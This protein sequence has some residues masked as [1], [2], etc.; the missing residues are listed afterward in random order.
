VISLL[1]FSLLSLL[2]FVYFPLGTSYF[3]GAKVL[4]GEIIIFLILIIRLFFGPKL[5]MWNSNKVVLT[6]IGMLIIISGV[7]LFTSQTETVIFG[8]QFRLQGTLLLWSLLI[9]SVLTNDISIEKYIKRWFILVV[10]ALQFIFTVLF[11]GVGAQRPIGTLGEPNALAANAVFLW[12]FLFI[13][14]R[15]NS[16]QPGSGRAGKVKAWN[17]KYWII[18]SAGMIMTCIIILVSGSRSGVIALG[19][20]VIFLYFVRAFYGRTLVATV[21]ALVVLLFSFATVPYVS[22]GDKYENRAEIWQSALTAAF[23]T[24]LTGVGF[25]NAEYAL[26]DATV[27]LNN[28]LQGYYVDSSHNIFLDYLVQGGIGA[29][30][31]L[32]LLIFMTIRSFV[33]AENVRNLVLFLGLIASLSF[34]PGSV[35]SLLVFWWLIGQGITK[36]YIN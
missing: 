34:N 26:H 1:I 36:R 7:H 31:A 11:I 3:E 19:V 2:Q 22:K 21:I 10:I 8:N 6:G 13:P 12:P 17:I 30:L 23:E 24:P 18:A 16:L 29:L 5:Q 33:R 20:Q 32:S 28:H 35:V 9:F 15:Q 25:G 14:F 27:K 4:F